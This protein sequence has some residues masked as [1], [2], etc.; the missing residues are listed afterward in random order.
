MKPV[1]DL[2]KEYGIVLEGGGAKGAYQVGAWKALRE[3][4]VKI[5]GI[6]GTSVGALN[7]ALMC[8]DE[9]ET[10]EK[11]WSGLTYSQ[12]MDVEDEKM[13]RLMEREMPFWEALGD[14]FKRMG[15]GGVDITPLKDL[16]LEV[17][18]EEKIR[19]SERELYIKTFSVDQFRELDIDLKEVEEGQMKDFLLASAYIYPLFKNEKLH[20]KT[21]I[22]G[23]A[24]NNVPLDSLVMRG[25]EDIIVIR[26]FG[27]GREKRVR[28]PEDTRILTIEPRVN[29]GNI[30]D[31]NKEKSVRNMKI[32]YYDAKRMIYGLKGRIY[33]IEENEEE[34]YYLNQLLQIPEGT[35]E[36]LMDWYHIRGESGSWVREMVELVLPGTAL[37]LKLSRE[38]DYRELY[39]AILEAT[40]KLCR[41]SKYRIYTVE[42]LRRAVTKKMAGMAPEKKEELPAFALFFDEAD[43]EE[44]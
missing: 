31:F 15:D 42:E 9:L 8:M 2:D 39:L 10:A 4:G 14:V 38:W 12:V 29:L 41:I 36:R 37:E 20:G 24:I 18:D 3:A 22:D 19:N 40:A 43:C 5:K 28:I 13:Q 25:Y 35:R 34:C 7:G 32:G 17:V 11:V 21:Y 44:E 1:I 16:I 6:A 26:I 30:I 27:I 23:G 33:Y